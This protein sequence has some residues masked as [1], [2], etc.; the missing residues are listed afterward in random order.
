MF[1]DM[2]HGGVLFAVGLYLIFNDHK[3]KGSSLKMLSSLRYMIA[4]MGF[5]AFYCGFIYNDIIGFQINLF[6]SCYTPPFHPDPESKH[7]IEKV[8][9]ARPDCVYPFGIDPIWGRS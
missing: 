4:L 6:S 2:A 5:F 9:H 7:Q 1:G 3:I 8:M